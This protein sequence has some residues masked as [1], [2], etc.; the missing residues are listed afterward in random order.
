MRL[1]Q[2]PVWKVSVFIAPAPGKPSGTNWTALTDTETPS[3]AQQGDLGG[4][5]SP[6]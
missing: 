4:G 6:A 3:G 2:C 1:F 5:V